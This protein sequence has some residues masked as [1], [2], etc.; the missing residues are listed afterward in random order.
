MRGLDLGGALDGWN[1]V[2]DT[3]QRPLSCCDN[4][5]MSGDMRK[6]TGSQHD[7]LIEPRWRCRAVLDMQVLLALCIG[8]GAG[9]ACNCQ[10]DQ[11]V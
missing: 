8:Q 2:K 5:A 7:L 6:P 3:G 4:I 1:P 9:H 10:L 11:F